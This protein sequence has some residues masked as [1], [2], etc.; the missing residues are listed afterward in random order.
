M[1]VEEFCK[2]INACHLRSVPGCGFLVIW[3]WTL[4]GQS[5]D[6]CDKGDTAAFVGDGSEKD[7]S[8]D[9]AS[10]VGEHS[11]PRMQSCVDFKCIGVT[12]EA[13]Y[14]ETLE[15][16]RDRLHS[17]ESVPVRIM[18]EPENIYD[19]K[20]IAFQ[21][22]HKGTWQR[23]G[24]VVAELCDEVLSAIND[25]DIVSVK[26]A[27]VKFKFLKTRPGYYASISITRSGEWSHAVH[28]SKNSFS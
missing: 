2:E 28:R 8:D 10:D 23:I 20:A 27:W 5:S 9:G 3:E 12:Q 11:E 25:G 13:I 14:Q 7:G 19:S 17:G 1:Q 6:E 21:C 4:V 22:F 15:E 16:V 18:P 26:F 24:Y